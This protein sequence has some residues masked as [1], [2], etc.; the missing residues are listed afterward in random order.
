MFFVQGG[1]SMADTEDMAGAEP[2]R[3]VDISLDSGIRARAMALLF[4]AGGT[5][6]AVSLVLPHPA[7]A[8]ETA[9]WS[10]IALAYLAGGLLVTVGTRL[11]RWAFHLALAAGSGLVLRAILASGEVNSFYSVWF[12][13]I[14]LYAFYFFSRLAAAAHVALV[15]ALYAIALI[16]HTPGS[17][18]ARWLTTVATL[19]IA[20]V[21]IDTL[22]RR[23]RMQAHYAA[24]SAQLVGIVADVAHELARLSD[25]EGAR[26]A[27]CA[28]AARLSRAD[29]VALW[30]PGTTGASLELT[31]VSGPRPSQ[32]SLPFVAAPGGAV[33][34][35]TNGQT[36]RDADDVA[37]P[38]YTGEPKPPRATL[39]QPVTRDSVPVAVLAFYW[40]V[41]SAD[42]QTTLTLASLLASE[43]SVTLERVELLARLESIARTDDLTGLPNRRAWEEE[44]PREL[45][46]SKR[47][48]R[49]LCVAMLDLDHFKA[50]NDERGHQA[51]DRFLKQAAAAWGTELRGTDFLARYG[52]EEFALALPGCTPEQAKD[53]AERMRAATPENE[54]CS[55]GIACWDGDEEAASLL[56]R[57]DAALYEA[58][59]K[60]RNL[61]VIL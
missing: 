42:D 2:A 37:V 40:R 27:L 1:T 45:L 23:A 8:D 11:P 43:A 9:L 60:G 7:N 33:Q 3:A 54:T 52:G 18:V 12:L 13:W 31:G 35:F 55:I 51:G 6:G 5:I 57:A 20:G 34:A 36:V 50:F 17:P 53:V 58:K 44:L 10:N 49:T 30:E 41:G 21:F 4:L 47:E 14:G 48:S 32:R 16:V 19:V 28:A 56:G 38:E 25:S 24:E 46:R 29:T 59:H 15:A 22:V 26:N 39:W 61:S